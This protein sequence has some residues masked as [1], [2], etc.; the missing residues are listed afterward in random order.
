MA[1][2][3]VSAF[4][5]AW[6]LTTTMPGP[7]LTAS[8]ASASRR[9]VMDRARRESTSSGVSRTP[10]PLYQRSSSAPYAATPSRQVPPGLRSPHSTVPPPR[11]SRIRRP[12]RATAASTTM[13]RKTA[14]IQAASSASVSLIPGPA[15]ASS[16]GP[17]ARRPQQRPGVFHLGRLF[18]RRHRDGALQRGVQLR[19]DGGGVHGGGQPGLAGQDRHPVVRHRQE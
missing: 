4:S 12:A 15:A 9:E 7:R 19:L 10:T 14:K 8:A 2:S 18:L 1:S 11:S 5:P 3:I 13:T 17:L 6:Q 16:S